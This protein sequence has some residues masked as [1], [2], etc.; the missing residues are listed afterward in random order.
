VEELFASGNTMNKIAIDQQRT[1]ENSVHVT[2]EEDE[3]FTAYQC[4]FHIKT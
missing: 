4:A 2:N 3:I 1:I